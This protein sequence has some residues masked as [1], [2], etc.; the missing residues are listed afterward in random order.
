MPKVTFT[1]NLPEEREE[2]EL[3]QKG[4]HLSSV[5]DDLD[6]YLRHKLKYE[7]LTEEQYAVYEDVRKKLYELRNEE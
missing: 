7:T 3:A 2:L 4:P 6:N 1:F 5:L